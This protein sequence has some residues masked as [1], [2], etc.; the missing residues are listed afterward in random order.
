MNNERN[1]GLK[2]FRIPKETLL[3]HLVE[4]KKNHVAEYKEALVIY[5][6]ALF[7]ELGQLKNK[8]K[9]CSDVELT[10]KTWNARSP[11]PASHEKE[12]GDIIMMLELSIDEFFELTHA[13]ILKYIKDEWTWSHTFDTVNSTYGVSKL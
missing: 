8:V 1:L 13:E 6:A 5:R 10:E 12:Y 3:E 4:N 11:V 7:K 9:N 2:T